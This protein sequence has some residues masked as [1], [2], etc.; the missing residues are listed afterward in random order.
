MLGDLEL[1]YSDQ[2]HLTGISMYFNFANAEGGVI[3]EVQASDAPPIFLAFPDLGKTDRDI[4][5]YPVQW[6]AHADRTGHALRLS[7]VHRQVDRFVTIADRILLGLD[8]GGSGQRSCS[9]R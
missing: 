7:V 1:F 4:I 2:T 3:G 9:P 5:K 8:A 6:R